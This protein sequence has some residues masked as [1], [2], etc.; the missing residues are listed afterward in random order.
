M[1]VSKLV[2]GLFL[3]AST[4]YADM[5][6]PPSAGPAP[7]PESATHLQAIKAKN[8][9]AA[10]ENAL[11][12]QV[13]L[14][15]TN[16]DWA[17]AEAALQKLVAMDATRWDYAQNLGDAQYN[18]G[19][20]AEA[21]KTYEKALPLAAADTTDPAGAK[22]A[23]GSMYTNEGNAYLKLKKNKD[24]IAAFDKGAPLSDNPGQ[25]YYN[26]CV[27]FYNAQEDKAAV[28]ACDKAIA[29]QPTLADAYYI[30]GSIL[31]HQGETDAKGNFTVP[32]GTMDALKGYLKLSPHGAHA[33]EVQQ[34]I[35]LIGSP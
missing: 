11:I 25:T 7:A 15:Q 20:F 9:E 2:P 12:A 21:T 14:A 31:V 8:A 13:G 6:A 17:G 16:K 28:S 29:A 5:G 35:D 24:A 18:Q 33:D 4:A 1:R 19:K 23:M 27:I 3:L 22:H 30:K 32:A 34:M 10:A 26:V